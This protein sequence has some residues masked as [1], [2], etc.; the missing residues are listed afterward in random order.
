MYR[1]RS[2]LP[3]LTQLGGLLTYCRVGNDFDTRCVTVSRC[4]PTWARDKSLPHYFIAL[5]PTPAAQ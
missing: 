4:T 5:I 2:E 1:Q 3:K